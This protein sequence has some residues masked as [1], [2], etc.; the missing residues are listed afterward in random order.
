MLRSLPAKPLLTIGLRRGGLRRIGSTTVTQTHQPNAP[1][2]LD[3]SFQTLLK[4]IDLSIHRHRT[5]PAPNEPKQLETTSLREL[6]VYA[7]DSL[8]E[9]DFLSFEDLELQEI[10]DETS[11]EQRS[12]AAHFGSRRI[13]AV[14]LPAELQRTI[15]QL[16][17]ES[18]KPMLHVDAKRLFLD[19]SGN[20]PQWDTAYDVRYKSR[21]QA[22]RHAQRDG[23]AFAS[24]AL[25]AHY[26]AI[27][28]VLDHVKQRLGP[29]WNVKRIVD[30]GSGVG[31]GLWAA[32]HAFQKSLASDAERTDPQMSTTTITSYV[33]IDKHIDLGGLAPAWQ[34]AFH[35]EDEVD[36]LQGTSTT[37]L[38][39][40]MLSSLS[41]PLARKKLVKEMWESGAEVLVLIDHNTKLGF[42]CIV[43]A[44]EML[45]RFGRREVEDEKMA[46][47]PI[48]GCHVVAPCPHDRACPLHHPGSIR[49]VCGF[50]QR[51]QRPDFVRKT[52]HSGIG[53][54]DSEYSYVVIRRGVRP[55]LPETK[56]GRVGD[57]GVRELAKARA[58]SSM[59]EL[60]ID[61]EHPHP[62]I[63]LTTAVER[64][65]EEMPE[66][67]IKDIERSLPE[68]ELQSA[69][70]A[71][72]Y[73]WP[74]LIFPPLKK[75]GHI[76]LDGCT[77]EGK[78]MRMTIPKSQ[79]KQPFYDA[80]K[81]RWGDIFPHDPKN[82]PQERYQPKR[83]GDTK[84]VAL[85][86][87]DIGKRAGNH[88]KVRASYAELSGDI[89]EQNRRLRRERK[90]HPEDE[91]YD[92]FV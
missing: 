56:V 68:E 79:G 12:P 85:K 17:S 82:K 27:Y 34:K 4:D 83:A 90:R 37:A 11:R 42:E 69:L 70:R 15:T 25:P 61:D 52:K 20:E 48:R 43:E 74:R 64:S 8:A 72:A 54:E 66:Q 75:S 65:A 47:A 3:P 1:V 26:C 55:T 5:R 10:A 45:L 9:N 88:K 39:A 63:N 59:T 78:I 87:E 32:S 22:A 51:L 36:R 33:G 92:D 81:S 13:G 71:E 7:N 41:S 86:G 50:S 80:R 35:E 23:T 84:T 67:S 76:I 6:E 57:V 73:S 19:E 40:F 53:H 30:W 38:S 28:A 89:K 49:L 58:K 46:D 29:S 2:E 21:E 24:V 91:A 62:T 16:I 18:D 44:R 77:A 60:V 31:S 14:I